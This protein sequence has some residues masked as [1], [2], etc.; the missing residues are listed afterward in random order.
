MDEE[1]RE[2][3]S[4]IKENDDHLT[5]LY[6]G[7]DLDDDDEF[8]EGFTFKSNK[9]SDFTKL[10]Q[11][12]ATNTRLD[13]LQ[14]N[15]QSVANINIRRGFYDGLRRNSTIQ[16]LVLLHAN[17]AFG[18]IGNGAL[19]TYRN[20]SHLTN[21]CIFQ[22]N[23]QQN[24]AE[25]IALTLRSCTNLK[26]I[27]LN[28]CNI[29]GQ[30]LIPIVE[31][32]RGHSSLEK[33]YLNFN[34][35][36]NDGC[37]SLATLLS[38]PNC[39]LQQIQLLD[40][41]IGSDGAVTIANSLANNTKLK[42]IHLCENPL[43]RFVEDYFCRR[44]LCNTASINSIYSS[45]HTL[46]GVHLGQLTT[47]VGHELLQ[48]LG[49]NGSKRNKSHVAMKKILRYHPNFDMAQLYD[50]DSEDEHTLK[51]LPFV[52]DW[53]ER[54]R[55]AVLERLIDREYD[56][57]LGYPKEEDPGMS[58]NIDERKLSAIYQFARDIPL[59]FIPASHVNGSG[60]VLRRSK[61]KRVGS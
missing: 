51:A 42:R 45:N 10:G 40:N 19:S 4:R 39:N 57:E 38:H 32:L 34:R 31:A 61:R 56:D 60:R 48:V 13:E 15:I 25:D 5:K 16:N 9:V 12:I 22:T 14:I 2:T 53:F 59:L 18:D 7:D 21:L 36:G 35:F 43:A 11:Y 33:L 54:A 41:N 58:Y 30:K 26:E 27:G 44:L 47:S 29:N 20:S 3:L 1:S 49:I 37:Q 24:E 52:I 46:C 8:R 23:L 50:W 17:D 55:E 28:E 6:I